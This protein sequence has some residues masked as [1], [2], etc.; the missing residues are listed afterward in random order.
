MNYVIYKSLRIAFPNRKFSEFDSY[1]VYDAWRLGGVWD[2]LTLLGIFDEPPN[3]SIRLAIRTVRISSRI[4]WMPCVLL[5][6][7]L[8]G[9]DQ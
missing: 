4:V 1:R 5:R 3:Y 9:S 8:L 2:F 7:R 6:S